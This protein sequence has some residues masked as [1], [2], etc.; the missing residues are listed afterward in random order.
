MSRKFP[1]FQFSART[2][3]GGS[4]LLPLTSA[5]RLCLFAA[6]ALVAVSILVAPQ[7]AQSQQAPSAKQ[8]ASREAA[9]FLENAN[10]KKLSVMRPQY[11][12][13]A[14]IDYAKLTLKSQTQITVPVAA[15][16][17]MR[18]VSLFLYA[19]ADG[20]GG[21][22]KARPNIVVDA[23]SM[24]GQALKFALDGAVLKVQ[25]PQAQTEAFTLNI[26]T[27][28]HV[29]RAPAGSEGLG[30]M[31]SGIDLGSIFGGTSSTGSKPKNQDYGLYTFG[32]DMMSLGAFW[33]PTLAVRRDGRWI[34]TPPE[35][36]G[37]VSYAESSD[38]DV[39]LT[40]PQNVVAA[41]PDQV[42]LLRDIPIVSSISAPGTNAKAHW[43]VAAVRDF[44]ILLSDQYQTQSKV[45]DVAGKQVRVQAMTTKA[46][47]AKSAQA[48]DIAGHALQIYAKRFGPYNYDTFTVAEAPI[49]GGAGGMEY[50][51]MTGIASLLYGDLG[52]QLGGL[53]GALGVPSSKAGNITGDVPGDDLSD[54]LGDASSTGSNP[55]GDIMAKQKAVVDSLFEETIAHEVAHQ[56]WAIGVGSDSERA[57]WLD[58]SLTNYSSIIYWEDRYGAAKGREMSD[59]HL[60]SAYEMARMLNV[61]DARADLKTSAYTDNLQYGAVVYGKGALFYGALRKLVGDAAFFASLRDYY[62]KFDGKLADKNDLRGVFKAQSPAKA[63][64]IDA[65]YARWIEGAHGDEDISGGKAMTMSDLLG[66]T[67]GE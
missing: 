53:T 64:Q 55:L 20:V 44:P 22:T 41:V 56:W 47:A 51:G 40:K 60:K 58:E 43:K 10:T 62:A 9:T 38:Y 30:G 35:G 46:N 7:L 15:H 14:N 18:D 31:L 63:A 45:F 54:V 32:G 2:A 48:I 52:A 33:Y 39:T 17:S 57:P 1:G 25:L 34:D 13:E 4:V 5:S 67:L 8:A 28:G 42:P 23:V 61:S 36:L 66:G 37:D 26:Q 6:S 19:N 65:L 21:A 49:R 24:N 27:H 3:P 16:D 29:P 50:S 11:K 12:I 59:A